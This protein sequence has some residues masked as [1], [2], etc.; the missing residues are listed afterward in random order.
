MAKAK[1]NV[2]Y[3]TS[4]S[5]FNKI[6]KKNIHVICDFFAIWCGP[7]KRIEPEY[8]E[9]SKEYK[10]I[11]FIKI[12]VDK[13]EGLSMKYKI[14]AMPTFIFIK[15]GS[16]L[17]NLR[18]KGANI[19]MIKNNIVSFVS[20]INDVIKLKKNGNKYYKNN[21]YK[22]AVKCYKNGLE[23]L[24]NLI[25][26]SVNNKHSNDSNDLYK[27]FIDLNNNI[28]WMYYCLNK[29]NEC[30]MYC[31]NVLKKDKINVKAILRKSDAY[32]ELKN[33]IK[34]KEILVGY[35]KHPK[36]IGITNDSIKLAMNK[37]T[38]INQLIKQQKQANNE[39]KN[40]NNNQT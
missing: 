39:N 25:K 2:T 24:S 38:D 28:S 5:E 33:Y 17:N 1:G 30:I 40:N 27:L 6:I 9:L 29:Y 4:E 37:K 19:N 12:D 11:K 13:L 21:D 15:N 32:R 7:C 16:E 26:N 35:L 22:N 36:N 23:M 20:N 14:Q 8:I 18:I 3:I 31:N 10:D 34:A